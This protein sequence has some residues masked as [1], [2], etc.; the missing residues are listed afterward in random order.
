MDVVLLFKL[1]HYANKIYQKTPFPDF[2]NILQKFTQ[3]ILNE[4][5]NQLIDRN[6]NQTARED[7][8][9]VKQ[10]VIWFLLVDFSIYNKYL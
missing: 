3:V 10:F 5:K 1:V 4:L 9:E 2:A 6:Q 7:K 8:A